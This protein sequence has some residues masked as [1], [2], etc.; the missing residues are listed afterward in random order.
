MTGLEKMRASCPLIPWD[1][2]PGFCQWCAKNLKAFKRR[3]TWCSDRCR[4]LFEKSH[5]W[6]HARAAA[7]ARARGKCLAPKCPA[8]PDQVDAHHIT[9]LPKGTG[10][11]PSCAHHG[12]NLE[13]L[14]RKHRRVVEKASGITRRASRA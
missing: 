14:C 8:A 1:G 12:D 11:G 5:I 13:V 9:P 10:Y 7:K 4:D 3:R 6:S 2:T